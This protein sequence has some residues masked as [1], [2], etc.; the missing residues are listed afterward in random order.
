MCPWKHAAGSCPTS[1]RLF[2]CKCGLWN[3][4]LESV[5]SICEL[6]HKGFQNFLCMILFDC[7]LACPKSLP[8]SKDDSCCDCWKSKNAHNYFLTSDP[9]YFIF[10]YSIAEVMLARVP[11]DNTIIKSYKKISNSGVREIPASLQVTIDT[12]DIPKREEK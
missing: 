4:N 6:K 11:L 5:C 1:Q 10:A 12:V 3:G 2:V 9:K 7:C 8:S